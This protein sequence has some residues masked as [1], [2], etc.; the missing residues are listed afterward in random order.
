MKYSLEGLNNIFEMAEIRVNK[1]ENKSIEVIQYKKQKEK[2]NEEKWTEPPKTIKNNQAYQHMH[3][4]PEGKEKEGI[5]KVFEYMTE[6][7]SGF[8]KL[9]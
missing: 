6:K 1:F 3:R 8:M 4:S 5:Q 9:Y 7:V 2:N